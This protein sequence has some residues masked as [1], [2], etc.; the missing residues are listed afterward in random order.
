MLP[1]TGEKLMQKTTL[2]L[3]SIFTLSICASA[4]QVLTLENAINKALS[5][6][7]NIIKSE[8]QLESKESNMRAALGQLLPSV[9]ANAGWNW[10]RSESKG[11]EFNFNGSI[12]ESPASTTQTR[13]YT[14][15]LSSNWTLFDGLA[16]FKFLRIGE[17]EVT[18]TGL[19]LSRLKQEIV[20]QTISRYLLILNAA[21]LVR[22]RED[23]LL[24]NQKNLEIV[25]MKNE[26]GTSTL[27]E[28][29]Q[30]QVRV[31][32]AELAVL[33]AKNDFET[34]KS[35]FL[36]FL[37]EDVLHEYTYAD[38]GE[39]LKEL[40]NFESTDWQTVDLDKLIVD[41]LKSRSDYKS[42]EVTVDNAQSLIDARWA[43]H[44]PVLTNSITYGFRGN[45]IS[46]MFENRNLSVSL[47]LSIP[48]FNGW[49]TTN[50]IEQA[51]IQKK[52]A[53]VDLGDL[54][55]SIKRDLQKTFLDLQTAGKRVEVSRKNVVAAEETRKIEEEKYKLGATTLLNV[56]I[57][58]SDLLDAQTQYVNS[59]FDLLTLEEKLKYDLGTLEVPAIK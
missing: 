37:G 25:T 58:N 24:W 15:G 9:S 13:S 38:P 7:P 55:R 53:E 49:I 47:N 45:T 46:D 23:N 48:I 17:N 34:T 27:A 21:E 4:Q 56:L 40:D 57:A 44:L 16:S 30:Q 31:G 5:K 50:Q 12:I 3:I 1:N 22:V 26:I 35:A 11:G 54:A 14:A 32:Q 39:L 19:N 28:V 59:R 51:I 29:Y 42:L 41:A 8:Y 20:Y 6:N 36:Y 18:Q 43:A 2:L 52:S 10:A 33:Q